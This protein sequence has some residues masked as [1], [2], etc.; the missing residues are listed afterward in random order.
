MK[1]TYDVP[2]TVSNINK[3]NQVQ[4]ELTQDMGPSLA[5]SVLVIFL[6]WLCSCS[7]SDYLGSHILHTVCAGSLF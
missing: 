6:S 3:W 1:F 2:Q 5:P 4:E 7:E